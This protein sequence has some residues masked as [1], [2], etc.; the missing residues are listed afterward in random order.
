LAEQLKAEGVEKIIVYGMQSDFCVRA[1]S[2]GALAAGFKVVVLKG[3][4][5]TYDEG[6]KTAEEIERSIEEELKDQGVEVVE[7]EDWNP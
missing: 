5:S 3:A 1:S 7:W 2:K 6:G 4:H